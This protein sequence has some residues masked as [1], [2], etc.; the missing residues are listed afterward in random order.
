MGDASPLVIQAWTTTPIN[1]DICASGPG[2][3]A[4]MQIGYACRRIT[5][6]TAGTL[7]MDQLGDGTTRTLTCFAGEVLDVEAVYLYSSSTAQGVKVY[8]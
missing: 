4:G 5:V 6:Q 3:G 2:G 7:V 1:F 8:W